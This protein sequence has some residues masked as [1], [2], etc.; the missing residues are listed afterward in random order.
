MIA[1]L[2]RVIEKATGVIPLD[3]PRRSSG[4]AKVERQKLASSPTCAV[5]DTDEDLNVHHIRPFYLFPELELEL[6][7]LIT[8]CRDHHFLFGH[9]GSWKSYNIDVVSDAKAWNDKI[10]GRP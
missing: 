8:L 2:K 1:L 6:S 4:W 5:C 10:K 7:N 9:L 3:A